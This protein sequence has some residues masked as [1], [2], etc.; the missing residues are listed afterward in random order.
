MTMA[1]LHAMWADYRYFVAGLALGL[2]P[3]VA[4]A[5]LRLAADTIITVCLFGVAAISDVAAVVRH[6]EDPS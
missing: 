5:A 2:A 1:D 4:V 3:L 6:D